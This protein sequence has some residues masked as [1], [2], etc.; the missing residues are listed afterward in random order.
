MVAISIAACNERVTADDDFFLLGG[1]S[2]PAAISRVWREL[3]VP[4]AL[5]VLFE[6]P[7]MAAT[8][9]VV[10]ALRNEKGRS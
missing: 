1:T 2:I 8:A 7:T 10:L 6:T 3:G 5:A 4:E 9:R